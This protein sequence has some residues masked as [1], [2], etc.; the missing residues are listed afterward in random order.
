MDGETRIGTEPLPTT[1]N[2]NWDI[3]SAAD[4]NGD[5][6]PDIIWREQTTGQ[7]AVWYMDGATRIGT[8]LLPTTTNLNWDIVSH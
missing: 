3:K 6:K 7:N 1:A 2:L 5:G 4:F 8:D